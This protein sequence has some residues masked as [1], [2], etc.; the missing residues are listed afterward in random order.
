[1]FSTGSR[2]AGNGGEPPRKGV[3]PVVKTL[4][5]H[6]DP[7]RRKDAAIALGRID[8][9]SVIPALAQA[10]R[11]PVKEVRAAAAGALASRGPPAIDALIGSLT[12]GNW[13][14]RY[15]AA[16]ALGFI[17]DERSVSA[18]I[19][20]LGDSRDHVRYMAAKGLGRLGDRRAV[21]PLTASLNDENEFVRRAANEALASLGSAS[22]PADDRRQ[23]IGAPPEYGCV[24]ECK[25]GFPI[26]RDQ[27]QLP[28]PVRLDEVMHP[29]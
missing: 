19:Q 5:T 13:V 6:P 1:M 9:D 21:G 27:C 2:S 11:D 26:P 28:E 12:D 29:I 22:D 17:R 10:L 23:V 4:L 8:D 15:R 14:V 20:V 16:E 3:N 18:L 25:G 24:D 7:S